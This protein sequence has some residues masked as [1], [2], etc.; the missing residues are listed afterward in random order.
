MPRQGSSRA[1]RVVLV[2]LAGGLLASCAA[3]AAAPPAA[4]TG[5]AAAPTSPPAATAAPASSPAAKAEAGGTPAPAEPKVFQAGSAPAGAAAACSG[6]MRKITLGVSVSPPNVVHTPPFVAR[7]LG[8]F[9]RR[10]I[11]ATI[12]QFEGGLS[13]TNLA[14]VAQGQAM[15]SLNEVAIGQGLKGKQVWGMAPRLPQA[16]VVSGAVKTAADLKGKRLS[17]AGGGVGSFNWRMGREVLKTAGLTVD[18]VQFISQGTAGRLPGLVTGQLDGVALHP[19]DVYLAR[20]QKPD[21]HVLVDL[22]QL[23]PLYFFNAYGVSEDFLSRERALVRDTVAALIEANRTIY[24][25]KE[26]VI[27]IMVEATEKPRDAV[28]YAYDVL[29]QK[30]V[31]SVNTGFSRE[32]T[33]WST[34]NSVENGDVEPTRRPTY[35]QVVAEDLGKE[36]LDLV[37]GPVTIGNCKD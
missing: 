3:P 1:L 16:Y 24:R 21:V 32:R 15:A 33:E 19:E 35:E 34:Q 18:D 4:P 8:Y 30:C 17:A 2:L 36:A 9:A 26:K 10:C 5:A 27:P 25:E 29:T 23:M 12:L 20:Q 22:D 7:A 31:W 13:A 14:A 6:P 37:G 28:E 11:D